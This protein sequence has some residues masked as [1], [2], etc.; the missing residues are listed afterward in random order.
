MI[1]EIA[2]DGYCVDSLPS[3][4]ILSQVVPCK[5]NRSP[6]MNS[7]LRLRTVKVEPIAKQIIKPKM[8]IRYASYKCFVL[9]TYSRF[10]YWIQIPVLFENWTFCMSVAWRV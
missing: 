5:E 4:M 2:I 1:N 9:N 8:Y 10:E 6:F 3:A 7:S